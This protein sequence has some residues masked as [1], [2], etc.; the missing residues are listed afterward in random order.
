MKASALLRFTENVD[1]AYT[2]LC[3]PFV[4]DDSKPVVLEKC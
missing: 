1:Y 4:I 3:K 2:M